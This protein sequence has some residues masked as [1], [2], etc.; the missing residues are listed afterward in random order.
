MNSGRSSER[1]LV[2]QFRMMIQDHISLDE[3]VERLNKLCF[4]DPRAMI[5]MVR[6]RVAINP[7]LIGAD[8]IHYEDG[9]E[10]GSWIGILDVLNTMIHRNEKDPRII[11]VH[12]DGTAISFF[13][14]RKSRQGAIRETRKAP[15]IIIHIVHRGVALCGMAGEPGSWPKEHVWVGVEEIPVNVNPNTHVIC[16]TCLERS[17]S[18]GGAHG[19]QK[20][21]V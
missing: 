11:D 14:T 15:L 1:R 18:L 4:L 3:L 16:E 7:V 17:S 21:T 13:L 2:E 6:H 19:E 5:E 9:G 20:K 10:E 12:D 8:E